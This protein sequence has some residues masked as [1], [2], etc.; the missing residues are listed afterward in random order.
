MINRMCGYALKLP[1]FYRCDLA[2]TVFLARLIKIGREFAYLASEASTQTTIL[3]LDDRL[4]KSLNLDLIRDVRRAVA[5]YSIVGSRIVTEYE[6]Y[7]VSRH[8]ER[9]LPALY[10]CLNDSGKL[11]LLSR[12]TQGTSS[13]HL[14]PSSAGIASSTT[15]F[16]HLI[17]L[18]STKARPIWYLLVIGF[19]ARGNGIV[20]DRTCSWVKRFDRFRSKFSTIGPMIASERSLHSLM[21]KGGTEC[22]W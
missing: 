6:M 4:S 9:P 20:G 1:G 12:S 10:L 5:T 22:P 3:R 16:T 18:Y 13:S 8:H 11:L 7:C 17:Y 2:S 21:H 14:R 19:Y 15:D